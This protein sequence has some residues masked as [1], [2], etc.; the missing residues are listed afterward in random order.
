LTPIRNDIICSRSNQ[1]ELKKH[2]GLKPPQAAT[3][4]GVEDKIDGLDEELIA[5]RIQ[6]LK[7]T[8][9]AKKTPVYAISAQSGQN[10]Q[11]SI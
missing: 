9:I 4:G 1:T 11:I 3:T 5:D 10:V 2:G 6:E 7:P 8:F